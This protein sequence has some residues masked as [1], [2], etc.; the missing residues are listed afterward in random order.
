MEQIR[1]DDEQESRDSAEAG[2]SLSGDASATGA[3]LTLSAWTPDAFY[4]ALTARNRGLV[5]EDQQAGLRRASILVA[6]C[7]GVGGAAVEPLVRA[8][9]GS[10]ILAD[11]GRYLLEDAGREAVR[12][13]DIGRYKA[14]VFA[15]R[16]SDINPFLQIR[17]DTDGVTSDNVS[18]LVDDA[19][20]IID[21]I[22]TTDVAALNAKFDLHLAAHKQRT[23]VISGYDVAGTLWT[24]VY[25][26][27]DD[28]ARL[29]DG[30]VTEAEVAELNPIGFMSR[31]F[32]SVKI[33]IEMLPEFERQMTGQSI[34]PPAL[35]YTTLLFGALSVR[36]AFEMLTDHPV[37]RSVVIDVPSL[38]R[39][40]RDRLKVAGRRLA[41]LYMVN[42]RLKGLQRSGR[43][44]VY[45][46]L[47]DE[48]FAE[49]RDYMEERVWESGSVIVRQGEPGRDFFVIVE[50]QVQVE[51]EFNDEE[52]EPEII[53][54]LGVGQFFGELSLLT[55]QPRNA[56]VVAST[57]CKVLSLSRDAFETYLNESATAR[58]RLEEISRT[59]VRTPLD[60][61]A[62]AL[63]TE[64][65]RR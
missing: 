27:R 58:H 22:S 10:I 35:G 34:A 38:V 7:G 61:R 4:E 65:T 63:V 15:E 42:H 51:R 56:S 33:P 62:A 20:L 53:A 23:P 46:P 6:G 41:M 13:Q 36:L 45:S 39:P 9:V 57:R 47:D 21:G 25:D 37:R 12:I 1:T 3:D 16:M 26:Y 30:L 49:L 64:D 40:T 11:N 18:T 29:F 52:R 44:G 28:D 17:V 8:G 32:S 48:V 14:T 5:S 60:D 43:L 50:G 19:D 31:L 2:G 59:R 54:R 55:D 24:A